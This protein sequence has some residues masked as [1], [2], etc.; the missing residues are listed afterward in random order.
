MS[1]SYKNKITDEF[2]TPKINK[3]NKG[4]IKDNDAIITF[5]FRSD[6]MRQIISSLTDENFNH[7]DTKNCKILVTSM[8]KYDDR[9]SFP[10]LYEPIKLNDILAEILSNNNMNL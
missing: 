10:V 7:F 1:Q 4:I 5:N 2:I 9:F 8:T 6:R 3:N